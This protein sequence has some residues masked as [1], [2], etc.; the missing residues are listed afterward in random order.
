MK[1]AALAVVILYGIILLLL[2]GPVL[3]ICFYE[4]FGKGDVIEMLGELFSAEAILYWAWLTV[5]M[6]C[7]AALLFVPARL[8]AGRPVR[9]RSVWL[10]IIVSGLLMACL[11]L[12][13]ICAVTEFVRAD[14]FFDEDWHGWLALGICLAL[15][16]AWSVVFCRLALSR[17][18]E[19]AL[20]RQCR[21][22]FGGSILALLVAVPTHI[23]ARHRDY[24]CAGFGTF[25]GIVFGLSVMIF[26]F[27]P[28]AFFLYV[29]RWKRLHPES[30]PPRERR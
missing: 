17:A 2:S 13:I 7:Q 16:A 29:A 23:V 12:G 25:V 15:W 14:P 28:G 21:N 27:G 22:L 18:P 5:M 10:A 20:R 4:E 26:A 9:R 30:G 24:C 11:L 3:V 8:A 6:L 19:D 1:K